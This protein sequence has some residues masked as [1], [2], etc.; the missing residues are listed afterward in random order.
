M[1]E[2]IKYYVWK[3]Q[4]NEGGRRYLNPER[5]ILKNNRTAVSD[6]RK[7]KILSNSSW[8]NCFRK[9]VHSSKIAFSCIGSRPTH[10][11]RRNDATVFVRNCRLFLHTRTLHV[12]HV[13]ARAISRLNMYM[14]NTYVP[15]GSRLSSLWDRWTKR[16]TF[17]ASNTIC[18]GVALGR[19]SL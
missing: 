6:F 16:R 1:G 18:L 12:T 8:T 5:I 15:R 13:I 11:L 14:Y 4:F 17:P 3:W 2:N 10:R 9:N 19:G 7:G